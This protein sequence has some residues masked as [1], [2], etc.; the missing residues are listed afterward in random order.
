M[1]GSALGCAG[2]RAQWKHPGQLGI[3]QV[4][5]EWAQRGGMTRPPW[6]PGSSTAENSQTAHSA[7]TQGLAQA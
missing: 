1:P 2:A 3:S 5:P 4:L 7:D 6:E